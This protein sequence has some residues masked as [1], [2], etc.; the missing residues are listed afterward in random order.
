MNIYQ[1]FQISETHF[2]TAYFTVDIEGPAHKIPF[3][4]Q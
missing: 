3:W 4:V 2:T 1:F